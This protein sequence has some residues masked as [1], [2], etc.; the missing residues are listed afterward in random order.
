MK[1]LIVSICTLAFSAIMLCSSTYA[2]FSMNK[3]VSASGMQV[4][5]KAEGSI[6]ITAGTLPSNIKTT[7]YDFNES[8]PTSLYASTHK[9]IDSEYTNGLARVSNAEN[10]NLETG[11]AK[12]SEANLTYASVTN[13]TNVYYKDYTVYIAGDGQAFTNQTLTISLSGTSKNNKDI[14][15]AISVDFYGTVVNSTSD[16]IVS[17]NNYLGTLNVAGVKNNTDGKSTTAYT[18]FTTKAIDEIPL[19]DGAKAYGVVMRVYY[20]GA[21]IQDKGENDARSAYTVYKKATGT[22]VAGTY[23]YTDDKGT[24]VAS[25]KTGES[26]SNLYVVDTAKSAYT[27]AKTVEVADLES[28]TLEATFLAAA[29]A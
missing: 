22:A 29:Q 13:G 15:K 17:S 4:T 3:T 25:V 28:V 10:I 9:T 18:T 11:T 27:Y 8:D 6:V 5:A 23:Y 2:W 14:N 20:D 21:L 19:A 24:S 12:N 26:V 1:K 7:N 16:T